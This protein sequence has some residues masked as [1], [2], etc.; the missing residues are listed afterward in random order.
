MAERT[1]G[2]KLKAIRTDNG[3]EFVNALWSAYTKEH[4]IIHEL[5]TPYTPQQDG[6]TERGHRT[7]GDH[8]RAVELS[9]FGVIL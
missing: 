1:T 5:T 9:I 8:A 4:G 2:K 7:I 6:I 3:P